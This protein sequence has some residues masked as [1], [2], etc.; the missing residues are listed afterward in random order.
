MRSP[1]TVYR[2]ERSETESGGFLVRVTVDDAPL[3][4]PPS[5]RLSCGFEWGY[6]GAGAAQLA[7]ALVLDATGSSEVA[8]RS[9]QW[10][11]W[12][13][14]A[15]WQRLWEITGGEIRAWLDQLDGET[16]DTPHLVTAD[17]GAA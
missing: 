6:G 7:Y 8:E 1:E 15:N 10:F 13:A 3:T 2:G 11:K 5:L 17:G 12:A 14:V 9:Y 4:L 16:A